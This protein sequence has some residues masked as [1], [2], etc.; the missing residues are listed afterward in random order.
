M[1]TYPA[2]LHLDT[3]IDVVRMI[4]EE[5]HAEHIYS[6]DE[7]LGRATGQWEDPYPAEIDPRGRRIVAGHDPELI[8]ERVRVTKIFGSIGDETLEW[9]PLE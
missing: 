6:A 1:G 8:A 2:I 5:I 7:R 4:T 3:D 9:E